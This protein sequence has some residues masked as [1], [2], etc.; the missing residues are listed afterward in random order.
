MWT[1]F[2]Y[3]MRRLLDAEVKDIE[4]IGRGDAVTGIML[5]IDCGNSVDRDEPVLVRADPLSIE[6]TNSGRTLPKSGEVVRV[7]LDD[8]CEVARMWLHE[9]A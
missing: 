6:P 4:R 8:E 1:L 9:I 3:D 2:R 5:E 7:V